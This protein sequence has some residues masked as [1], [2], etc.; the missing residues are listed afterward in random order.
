MYLSISC[1]IL[2]FF[3]C[4]TLTLRSLQ[5]T[6]YIRIGFSIVVVL[7]MLGIYRNDVLTAIEFMIVGSGIVMYQWRLH[8]RAANRRPSVTEPSQ[9]RRAESGG[10]DGNTKA[11]KVGGISNFI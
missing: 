8:T 6:L 10:S 5:V 1:P 11:L 4:G 9:R 3:F 2:F 7:K